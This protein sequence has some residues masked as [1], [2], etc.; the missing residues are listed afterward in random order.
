MLT[1][2]GQA[3][4]G[5]IQPAMPWQ[6][7]IPSLLDWNTLYNDTNAGKQGDYTGRYNEKPDDADLDLASDDSEEEDA[8]GDLADANDHKTG[9]LAEHFPLDGR[10]VNCWIID[11]LVQ[12]P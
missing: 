11:L 1:S 10:E 2:N 5:E 9:H 8:Y 12:S 7:W 3:K 4:L 6:S